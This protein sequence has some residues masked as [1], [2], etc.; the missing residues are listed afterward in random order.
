[1]SSCFGKHTGRTHSL[2]S[3]LLLIASGGRQGKEIVL[4]QGREKEDVQNLDLKQPQN[5]NTLNV[6]KYHSNISFSNR[7]N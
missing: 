2:L 6:V 3:D 1:M 7:R 5:I 4:F